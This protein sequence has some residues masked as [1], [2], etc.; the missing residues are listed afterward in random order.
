MAHVFVPL[1]LDGRNVYGPYRLQYRAR[2]E[3]GETMD[4]WERGSAAS[5]ACGEGYGT[6]DGLVLSNGTLI[7]VGWAGRL[8]WFHMA[9]RCRPRN[10]GIL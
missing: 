6:G 9:A 3:T 5:G 8:E 7:L 1:A 2:I 4:A 10:G